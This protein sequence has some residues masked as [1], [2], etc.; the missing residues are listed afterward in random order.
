[1]KAR[2]LRMQDD[3]NSLNKKAY[4]LTARQY[5]GYTPGED[6]PSMRAA[7]RSTFIKALSGQDVVEIGCGPGVDA[8]FLSALGLNVTATDF[9]EEFIEIVRERFPALRV[10]QMDMTKP[11]LPEG[12]YDGVYAFASFIHIPRVQAKNTL[13]G[14]RRLLRHNGILFMS[15]IQSSKHSEYIIEDWAGLADNP[16]LFTCHTHREIENLLLEVGFTKVQFFEFKTELYEKLPR[17]VER[18]VTQYQVLAFI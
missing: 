16:L 3:R 1:M 2:L 18:G 12:S 10:H 8:N 4:D 11:D 9:S 7:C 17:L 14:F 6:D 13:I 5:A 15:L